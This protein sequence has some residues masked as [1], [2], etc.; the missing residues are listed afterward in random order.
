M[1][2]ICCQLGAREHYA[3]PRALHA[4]GA[5]TKLVTDFWSSRGSE[6]L[7]TLPL[8][9]KR[10][11]RARY[12]PDLADAEVEGLNF[13][14]L[15]F[16]IIS[17]MR[18]QSGW[19]QTIARNR[20]FQHKV[21]SI[22]SN[23][24]LPPSNSQPILFAYSYAALELL[25]HAKKHGWQTVL[26]QIDPGPV[27]EKIVAEEVAREPELGATWQPAPQAYWDLWRE[28]C[29]LADRI[30]V[31][32]K[33]ARSA[34]EKAGI[35]SNKIRII[36]LAYERPTETKAFIRTYPTQFNQQ[37]PLRV[38]F[39]GQINL[40][41]GVA[42]LLKAIRLLKNEPIEFQF[43]GPVQISIPN[44]LKE[45]V[46]LRWFGAVSRSDVDT[47][48]RNADV[49]IFPT[50]SDGFG[51]TQLEAQAWSL[52]IIAS[53]FCGEVVEDG[54]NGLR[55]EDLTAEAIARAVRQCIVNP[56]LLVQFARNSGELNA[57]SLTEFG[58]GLLEVG[59]DY[60]PKADPMG[61]S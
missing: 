36:P 48:Y 60:L 38:L 33:W 30:V 9:L 58:E 26:G 37:R 12:H 54:Q 32:S 29:N 11:L 40:R 42:Q 41:K 31:N 49:L 46:R 44:D 1:A 25:K 7:R 3:V 53:R 56:E 10:D 19:T 52:P 45:S 34:L 2:W 61:R 15:K 57:F 47:F 50:L 23:F 4:R 55:L 27:E 21:V 20:W 43:V 6:F 51:L 22:L 35:W 16:E 28:E 39:L 5:L 17:R 8:S 24:E 14:M 13:S 18:R 59:S